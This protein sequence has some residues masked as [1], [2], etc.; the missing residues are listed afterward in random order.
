MRAIRRA[1]LATVIALVAWGTLIPHARAH[2]RRQV[3]TYVLVVG[4][5]QEPP[6]VEEPNA[7]SITIFRSDGQ[8]VDGA[9][10]TLKVEVTNGGASKTFDLEPQPGKP[11]GYMA[12]FIPT[13]TG[14]YVFRFFG[15]IENTDI[16]ERFESGP[17]RFDDVVSKAEMEFPTQVPTNGELAAQIQAHQA[18]PAATPAP[19]PASA[20]PASATAPQATS[21]AD[22]A[23]NRANT[24]LAI[25]IAGLVVGLV[26][27]G[28][29]V[30]G[31][32]TARRGGDRPSREPR[33]SE[34][35]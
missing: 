8:P 22:S 3:G 20:A 14:S 7:A 35:I 4:F 28:L 9:E 11:G 27:A 33:S 5:L 17:N 19:T 25:G 23:Q 15:K 6:L 26:G 21:Q 24:A 13:K 10:K 2:E 34:P 31:F 12:P 1:A 18:A 29:G 30:Y 16:N 32:T